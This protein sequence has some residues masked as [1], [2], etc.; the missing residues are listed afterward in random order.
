[1]DLQTM[2][3][4]IK[5]EHPIMN[6]AG[7]GC[8]TLEEVETLARTPI[9]AIVVGSIT[10]NPSP[11]NEGNA[12]WA[13]PEGLY[14][15]NS[16]GLPNQGWPYY[17]ENLQMM[18]RIAHNAGKPLVVSIACFSPEEYAQL[19]GFVAN[20]NVDVTELNLGC[21]NVWG[22]QGQKPIAS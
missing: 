9:S 8:K 6:G 1:M 20:E 22:E 17:G 10:M 5:L 16:L 3:G 12:Y 19:A 2:V 11:G 4:D 21:P 14:S 13:H 15:L 7:W 18:R